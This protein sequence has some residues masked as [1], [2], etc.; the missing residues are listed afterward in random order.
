ML[1]LQFYNKQSNQLTTYIVESQEIQP[2]V[3]EPSYGNLDI[4]I[5]QVKLNLSYFSTN[6]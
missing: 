3:D 5:G 4:G 2:K 6:Y 1:N